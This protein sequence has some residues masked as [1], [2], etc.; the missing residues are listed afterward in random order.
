MSQVRMADTWP[1]QVSAV[2]VVKTSMRSVVRLFHFWKVVALV[3]VAGRHLAERVEHQYW[4]VVLSIRAA[5]DVN[6][7]QVAR[8]G[9]TAVVGRRPCRCRRR[10][11]ASRSACGSAALGDRGSCNASIGSRVHA[12]FSRTGG[13]TTQAG[14]P[15]QRRH[16]K[17]EMGALH[18]MTRERSDCTH[19]SMRVRGLIRLSATS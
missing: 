14:R 16:A 8:S 2:G 15:G 13:R 4:Q 12:P 5:R 10:P 9:A 17:C 7:A 19:A 18:R 1:S 6:R 11:G 3:R